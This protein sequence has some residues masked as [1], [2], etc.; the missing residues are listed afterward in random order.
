MA[1]DATCRPFLFARFSILSVEPPILAVYNAYVYKSRLDLAIIRF[2]MQAAT[3]EFLL[4]PVGIGLD[5]PPDGTC[6]IVDNLVCVFRVGQSA[7]FTSYEFDKCWKLVDRRVH[8]SEEANIQLPYM[9]RLYFACSR[10]WIYDFFTKFYNSK[11]DLAHLKQIRLIE[12]GHTALHS[13]PLGPLPKALDD[14]QHRAKP[15]N[16]KKVICAR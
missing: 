2:N 8:L 5:T 14:L 16:P 15:S 13:L 10:L 1:N 4:E 3:F 11:S 12:R 9:S 6:E 7:Y